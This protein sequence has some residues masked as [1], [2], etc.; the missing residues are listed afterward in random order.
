MVGRARLCHCTK[1]GSCASVGD[2]VDADLRPAQVDPVGTAPVPG[3]GRAVEPG[4]DRRDVVDADDPREPAAAVL[5]AITHRAAERRAV[6]GRV[7]ERRDDLE[8]AAVGQRQHE[9]ARAEGRV[10]A[11]VGEARAEPGAEALHAGPESLRAG[12]VAD[13]VETH[14]AHRGPPAVTAAS[15]GVHVD[16]CESTTRIGASDLGVRRRRRRATRRDVL[17]ACRSRARRRRPGAPARPPAGPWRTC[18]GS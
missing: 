1:N 2:V 7:V 18:S 3:G 8:V 17:G 5:G 9:V 12:G 16:R 4:L 11:A 10:D 15:A 6:D 14:D 13:M